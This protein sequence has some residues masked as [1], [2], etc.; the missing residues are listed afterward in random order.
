MSI[1]TFVV[2][3]VKI[4]SILIRTPTSGVERFTDGGVGVFAFTLCHYATY[5]P[6]VIIFGTPAKGKMLCEILFNNVIVLYVIA[7]VTLP[8]HQYREITFLL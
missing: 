2:F 4:S 3:K 7:E 6:G 8:N 1:Y 5:N